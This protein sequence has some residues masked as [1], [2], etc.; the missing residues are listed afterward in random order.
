MAV[1]KRIDRDFVIIWCS[2]FIL[3]EEEDGRHGNLELIY[4]CTADSYFSREQ[5]CQP[6]DKPFLEYGVEHDEILA[7]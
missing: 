1:T 7:F 5:Y 4:S 6:T 3:C 2:F